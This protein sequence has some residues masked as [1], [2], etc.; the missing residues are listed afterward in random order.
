MTEVFSGCGKLLSADGIEDW[1]VSNVTTFYQSFSGDAWLSDVS[2]LAG[3][4]AAATV[5]DK[6]FGNTASILSVSDFSGWDFS[7]ATLGAM[8][9]C[10]KKHY[11][12]GIDQ[13]VWENGVGY[14]FDY[15]GNT[16]GYGGVMPLTEYTKDASSAGTWNVNGTG[17]GAFNTV[18]SN[19]PSWN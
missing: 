5:Y 6:M 2:A 10:F 15:A 12:G 13:D 14:Y 7:N 11:S 1:D 8:F 19:I 16:Y 4:S 9:G 17:I 18:W 3:W